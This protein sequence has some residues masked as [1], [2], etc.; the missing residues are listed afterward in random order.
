V[1][2]SLPFKKHYIEHSGKRCKKCRGR[3]SV[4]YEEGKGREGDEALSWLQT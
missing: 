2:K 3:I 4:D 1:K